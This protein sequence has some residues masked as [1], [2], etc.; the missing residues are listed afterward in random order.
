M[1]TTT[2]QPWNISWMVLSPQQSLYFINDFQKSEISHHN[3]E[4]K[5]NLIFTTITG[6]IPLLVD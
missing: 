6:L 4:V 1:I 3:K 5:M 2:G